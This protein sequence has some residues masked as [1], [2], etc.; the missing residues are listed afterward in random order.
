MPRA[1]LRQGW[2]PPDRLAATRSPGARCRM[3]HPLAGKPAPAA[4]LVDLAALERAYHDDHPDPGV[5]EQRVAFGTSG[6]RGSA[7]RRSFNEDHI[8]AIAAAI[9]DYR[10]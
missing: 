9:C 8:V 3:T 10:S 7:L 1:P 5:P 2:G 6:H 4:F